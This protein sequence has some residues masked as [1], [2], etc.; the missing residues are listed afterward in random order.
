MPIPS[1]FRFS[2]AALAVGMLSACTAVGPDYTAPNTQMPDSWYVELT[3]GLDR[4]E[5][6]LQ[7]WW[8]VLDDPQLNDLI[9]RAGQGNIGLQLAA[10]RV[11]EFSARVGIAAGEQLPQVDAA[12]L[13]EYARFSEGTNPNLGP[14]VSRQDTLNNLGMDSSWDIDLWGR[15]AR[16]VESAD[17]SF[18]ST[19][20]DYRDVLVSLYGAVASAYVNVRTFQQRIISAESNVR[21]QSETLRLVNERRAAGLSSDLDVAQAKLNL[22]R[23]E[24]TIPV[25]KQQLAQQI[26][27][28]GT[29]L[30]ERPSVLYP[31]ISTPVEIPSPPEEVLVG[32]PY[33]LL[34]QRPDVRSAERQLAAQTAQIGVAEADLY[35]RLSL[36]G[37]F[38]FESFDFSNWFSAGS[39]TYGFG[40]SVQWQ[41]FDG[42]RIRSNI[43]AQ[44]ALTQQLLANYEQTVLDSLRETEDAMVAFVQEQDRRDSLARSVAAARDA[45]RLVKTLYV[46]GL[47]D[48]QNVQDTERNQF[49]QEDQLAE[50]AGLV[51][52]SLID[53]YTS[54]GGGW[55]VREAGSAAAEGGT[56]AAAT[57][58]EEVPESTPEETASTEEGV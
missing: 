10:A 32:L 43:D 9:E 13:I 57:D 29:L 7:T 19:V 58:E 48:F 30:G 55:A 33:D 49:E 47:T 15:I 3:R 45:V 26:H 31:E 17:A 2:V 5:A 8:T 24:S 35:P 21:T 46:T 36:F 37:T 27:L 6:D 28:L 20:E 16:S 38:A 12:G 18:Q 23:T 54:I 25:F 11:E 34:R 40:P 1:F 42:G 56:A 39:L 4:G 41:V 53:I 22:A 51:T 52:L 50:S 44:D 14:D